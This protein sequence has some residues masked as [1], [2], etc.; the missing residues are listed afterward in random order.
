MEL[1][2]YQKLTSRTAVYPGQASKQGLE[3]TLF[4]LLGEVGEISNLYKKILR[5]NDD[6]YS[7]ENRQ[8]LMTE[9]GDA[10]WYLTQFLKEL[11]YSLDYAAQINVD[12]LAAR[13][14]A[15]ELKNR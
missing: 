2:E 13:A 7:Y 10:L 12:K 5:N 9:T 4:G 14:E 3:Y 1:N 6:P 8:K 11:G 15:G